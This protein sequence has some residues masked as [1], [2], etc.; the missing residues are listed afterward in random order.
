MEEGHKRTTSELTYSRTAYLIQHCSVFKLHKQEWNKEA[1]AAVKE[2]NSTLVALALN[3]GAT[4]AESI[5]IAH[6]RDMALYRDMLVDNDNPESI[7][8]ISTTLLSANVKLDVIAPAEQLLSVYRESL[9]SGNDLAAH[10]DAPQENTA[11]STMSSSSKNRL[12]KKATT[13]AAFF[14]DK[15]AGAAGKKKSVLPAKGSKTVAKA[16]KPAS[17]KGSSSN[18]STS[19][20]K[21]TNDT[22][23]GV[24][25]TI[26]KN[27]AA[28]T[29]TIPKK[30]AA[31]NRADEQNEKENN[32]VADD[33]VGNAD[34]FV[35]DLDDE[36]DDDDVDEV[37]MQEPAIVRENKASSKRR[38]KAIQ[39]D[40]DDDDDNVNPSP[41]K[42]TKQKEAKPKPPVTGAMDAFATTSQS[43]K[44][45]SQSSSGDG[46]SK[47]LPK[48]RRRKKMVEKTTMDQS[49]YLHTETQEIWEDVPSD[50]EEPV[51]TIKAPP[52]LAPIKKKKGA[53]NGKSDMKQGSLMG[54]FKKK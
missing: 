24:T 7:T 21:G 45:E 33:V 32:A 54:F 16:K 44:L 23:D 1:D 8:N 36:D 18:N 28:V 37:V 41:D 48:K 2:T 6:E 10:G 4:T 15:G 26:P 50:E 38:A 47:Q 3:A 11:A 53:A 43:Q 35:G 29:A 25:A 14:G 31:V 5:Q 52:K 39:D 42:K 51:S 46:G 30:S 34:N 17:K 20:T 19:D 13:A 40:D 27:S 9:A 49:G 12:P 22:K